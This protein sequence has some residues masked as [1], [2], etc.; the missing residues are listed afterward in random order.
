VTPPSDRHR[1]KTLE[2][3]A[4]PV[5]KIRWDKGKNHRVLTDGSITIGLYEEDDNVVHNNDKVLGA[6]VTLTLVNNYVKWSG[7]RPGFPTQHTQ[8]RA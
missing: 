3:P 7:S 8:T 4:H 1:E 6:Y 2:Y 5:V